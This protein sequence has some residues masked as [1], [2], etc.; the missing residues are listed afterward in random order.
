MPD[1]TL[2]ARVCADPGVGSVSTP[3]LTPHPTHRYGHAFRSSVA[4]VPAQQGNRRGTVRGAS[5]VAIT[6][7]PWCNIR[8][9]SLSDLGEKLY[10]LTASSDR[11]PF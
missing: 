4:L 3:A 7:D 9:S 2:C 8:A 6:R 5:L 11:R 10:S 1:V